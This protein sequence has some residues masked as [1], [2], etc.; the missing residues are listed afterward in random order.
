LVHGIFAPIRQL[1]EATQF[2]AGGRTDIKLDIERKDLIGD[3]AI[4]FKEMVGQIRRKREELDSA[5]GKLADANDRLA[6]NNRDL[7]EKVKQRTSEYEIANAR[8]TSE[9]AEKEDFLRAVSH[10]LNAPLRNINGMA[11]LLLAKHRGEF[12]EG[13]I[14]RLERIQKNVEVETELIS[15]LLELSRIKTRRQKIEMVDVETTVRDLGGVFEEDLRSHQIQLLLETSLP[16][17][18]AEKARIRQVFQNLIDNAIKY[19]GDQVDREIRIGCIVRPTEAEFYVRDT[20]VGIE[21]G[22]IHRIFSIFRRGRGAAV[23]NVV[24]KGVG[25]AWVKSIIETYNGNIWVESK[26]GRG[27]TFR[28]TINTKHLYTG[29]PI[30]EVPASDDE[31]LEEETI[32]D[33]GED[34]DRQAA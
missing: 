16:P 12:T 2:M 30:V 19:M 8:L 7:E 9:I 24:G 1:V 3:L 31:P 13:V 18:I 17:L 26:F 20:G 14:H 15:E 27:S 25:L 6:N 11:S 22:D 33:T 5:N 4:S 29:G 23:H 34:I 21:E 10:D 28:F 32:V